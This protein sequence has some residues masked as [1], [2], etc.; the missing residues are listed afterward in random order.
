MSAG[1]QAAEQSAAVL[2]QSAEGVLEITL[3]RPERLNALGAQMADELQAALGQAARDRATRA[4]LITGAG[5][6]FCAGADLVELG[7][8]QRGE[9]SGAPTIDVRSALER[10]Y[11]PLLRSIRAIDKPVISA[12]GGPAVG[13]GCS[14]ALACDLVI[15]SQSAYFALIFSRIGLVPDGGASLLVPLRAGAGRFLE[16]AILGE[17]VSAELALSW[18]LVNRVVADQELAGQAR[19]LAGRLAAGPT[20]AYG[21]IKRELG[22]LVDDLLDRALAREAQIQQEMAASADAAEG[23]LAFLAKRAAVFRGA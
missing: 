23:I 22:G 3:N 9:R 13:I 1:G 11:N 2:L 8:Q 20:L 6:A 14:L 18:G 21:G 12:V 4:V 7:E 17:R 5:R 15:A 10:R 16:M 19:E